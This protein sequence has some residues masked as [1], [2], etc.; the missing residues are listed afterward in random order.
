[1]WRFVVFSVWILAHG[2]SAACVNYAADHWYENKVRQENKPPKAPDGTAFTSRPKTISVCE[3]EQLQHDCVDRINMYR[4]GALLFS[5]GTEDANVKAFLC[6]P[7]IHATG[8]VRCSS[9]AAMGDLH[10]NVLNN[11]GADGCVGAHKNAFVCD[12]KRRAS[13]NA[14]CARGDGA[15]GRFD[16]AKYLTYALVR[17]EM[18]KALQTMWDEGIKDGK[19]GHWETM[20]STTFRYV[21]CGFAWTK[22]GRVVINQDFSQGEPNV[23]AC[24]CQD[25]GHGDPDGCGGKCFVPGRWYCR[26]PGGATGPFRQDLC[27]AECA[28]GTKLAARCCDPDAGPVC[29]QTNKLRKYRCSR[30]KP[31]CD[32][33]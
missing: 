20:R 29:K 32:M 2:S 24:S 33:A 10:Y 16:R 4:S 8:N 12:W 3:L 5:D 27:P 1:M 6:E 28:S 15:W 13:Q 18:N 30:P 11:P 23:D 7:L 31:T 19:K 9:A 26:E 21:Q 22:T 25:K 14:C 17:P